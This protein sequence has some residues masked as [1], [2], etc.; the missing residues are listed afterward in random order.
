MVL[1]GLVCET[2]AAFGLTVKWFK[3]IAQGFNPGL[4]KALNRPESGDRDGHI[5][6]GVLIHQPR[7]NIGCRFQGTSLSLPNPGLKPGAEALGY[8]V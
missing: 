8:S 5:V 4:R 7:P 1:P 6:I 3:R 2:N